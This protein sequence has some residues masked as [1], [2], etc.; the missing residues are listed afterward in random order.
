MAMIETEQRAE[1]KRIEI[2]E[3]AQRRFIEDGYAGAGMEAV[4]RDMAISTATLY[5]HFASK[6]ELFRCVAQSAIDAVARPSTTWG[7]GDRA[8]QL[9]AFAESY[10]RFLS[11]ASVQMLVRVFIAEPRRFVCVATAF[12][13]RGRGAY[14]TALLALLRR[15]NDEGRLATPDPTAAAAQLM[16]MI[17][18]VALLEPVLGWAP[19]EGA[20]ALSRVCVEA[21][22]TFLARWGQPVSTEAV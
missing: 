12:D 21:V 7:R 11:D 6:A 15:L 5:D 18:H 22:A 2:I 10:A 3:V 4:A 19:D 14:R 1:R 20:R 17:E 13:A 16:G 8:A 9:T